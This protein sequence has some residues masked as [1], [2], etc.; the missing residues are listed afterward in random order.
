MLLKIIIPGILS[1]LLLVGS[2]YLLLQEGNP[3]ALGIAILFFYL[4]WRYL[5]RR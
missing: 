3:L 4:Q 5:G 2:T 1:G